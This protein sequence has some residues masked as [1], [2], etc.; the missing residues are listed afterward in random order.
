MQMRRLHFYL[1]TPLDLSQNM[2]EEV[3]LMHMLLF[4]SHTLSIWVGMHLQCV[5]NIEVSQTFKSSS[6][7]GRLRFDQ[8]LV[9]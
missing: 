3:L 4:M 7:V 5:T 9:K 8:H 2:T 6:N 1:S